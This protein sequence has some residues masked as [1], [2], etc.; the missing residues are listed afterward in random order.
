MAESDETGDRLI[1]AI[2]RNWPDNASTAT[3]LLVRLFRL[4]DL[5]WSR[6]NARV[7]RAGLTWGEFE[8]LAALT[9][10]GPPFQ[11]TPTEIARLM[12]VTSGGL[13]KI[14]Q[15]LEAKGLVRRAGNRADGRSC[16]IERTDA[17]ARQIEELVGSLTADSERLFTSTLTTTEQKRLLGSLEKLTRAEEKAR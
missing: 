2:R 10:G 7:R 17:G 12:L 3:E 5:V 13:A 4:R 1:G 15:S 6:S 16:F 14:L 11:M 9:S 8:A